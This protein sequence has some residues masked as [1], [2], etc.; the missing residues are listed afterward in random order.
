VHRKD[1]KYSDKL[2]IEVLSL[3]METDVPLRDQR[4]LDIDGE[5]DLIEFQ[6]QDVDF[7]G[8]WVL[9]GFN[10]T[11]TTAESTLEFTFDR[12]LP[13]W[14]SDK[15]ENWDNDYRWSPDSPEV[16]ARIYRRKMV[17]NDNKEGSI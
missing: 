5:L 14:I 3:Q 12:Y 9:T 10:E 8:K 13:T 1:L 2:N 17:D 4:T 16:Y 7:G 11:V 15:D 6:T